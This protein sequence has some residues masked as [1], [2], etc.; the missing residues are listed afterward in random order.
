MAN[1][2]SCESAQEPRGGPVTNET[3]TA[4]PRPGRYRHYK[5]Q[6]Y[7]V[8]AEAAHTETG[9]VFVVYRAL[10]G[11]QSVWIRPRAMFC[12][13]VQAQGKLL[14]RFALVE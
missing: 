3:A 10:Y 14:P 2:L 1:Q 11:D 9:E 12:E 8:L 6:E 13:S 5:G 7:E 4:M